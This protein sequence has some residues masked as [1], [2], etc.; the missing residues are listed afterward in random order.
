MEWERGGGGQV[1][2]QINAVCKKA[3]VLVESHYERLLHG[4]INFSPQIAP[5]LVDRATESY[6]KMY[7]CFLNMM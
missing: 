4:G 3:V 7:I 6:R 1:G 5:L 2:I